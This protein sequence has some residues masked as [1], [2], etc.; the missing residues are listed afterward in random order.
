VI[1]RGPRPLSARFS[2][3]R[4]F[5]LVTGTNGTRTTRGIGPILSG[6]LV[7]LAVASSGHAAAPPNRGSLADAVVASADLSYQTSFVINC[8]EATWRKVLDN[9]W[10]MGQL[11]NVYGY[12]P[13]YMV[14]ATED[15]LHVDDPTGL[16][17]DL[18]VIRNEPLE[19]RYFALGRL[20]YRA[21]PFFNSGQAVTIVRS[22]AVGQQIR[23]TM[24]VYIRA[25]RAISRTALWA[26]HR[27]VQRKVEARIQANLWA[28]VQLVEQIASSPDTVLKQL[29]SPAAETFRAVFLPPTA[30]PP[31][32]KTPKAP[33]PVPRR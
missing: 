5:G 29:R 6:V 17:S 21:V 8:G 4:G 12:E 28:G 10:L 23:G 1:R 27:L 22:Q 14:R 31:P 11:W 25:D 3:A 20:T 13:A 19:R 26:G 33:R 24:H 16:S 2:R 9:P 18:W 32:T 30:P 7:W 15:G